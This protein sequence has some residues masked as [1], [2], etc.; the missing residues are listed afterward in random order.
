MTDTTQFQDLLWI[1]TAH[2]RVSPLASTTEL[3]P[4]NRPTQT[5]LSL[6]KEV[7]AIPC[8]HG[9][10]LIK[11][12]FSFVLCVWM[13]C[14]CALMFLEPNPDPP[15][16]PTALWTSQSSFQPRAN[17]SVNR[18]GTERHNSNN[19][20]EP[21]R[22]S[23]ENWKEEETQKKGGSNVDLIHFIM[24]GA[25]NLHSCP[26]LVKSWSWRKATNTTLLSQHNPLA[27]SKYLS[28]HTQESIALTFTKEMFLCNSQRA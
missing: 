15:Q 2:E 8:I 20:N 24:P 4:R 16:E 28:L 27:H 17:L 14:L 22:S 6:D 25:G 3:S 7:E 19:L 5:Q 9:H 21:E 1:G 18:A 13:F 23:E 10:L 26:G 11:Y 12:L